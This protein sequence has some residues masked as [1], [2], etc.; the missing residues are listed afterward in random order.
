MLKGS[1]LVQA[2]GPTLSGATCIVAQAL[3]TR[4][5]SYTIHKTGFI[6]IS[7]NLSKRKIRCRGLR[8]RF[9]P[10]GLTGRRVAPKPR[11]EFSICGHKMCIGSGWNPKDIT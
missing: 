1:E 9:Q 2:A 10:A 11:K 4:Q 6:V 8:L 3:S 7:K 5:L